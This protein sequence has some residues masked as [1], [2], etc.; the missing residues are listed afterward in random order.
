MI[1]SVINDHQHVLAVKV[2]IF[3]VVSAGIQMY[4]YIYI[5]VKLKDQKRSL[6]GKN[7]HNALWH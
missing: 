4:L 3:R 7:D 5:Y 1:N 6:S 2:A